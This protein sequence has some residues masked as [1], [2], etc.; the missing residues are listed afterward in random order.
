M[1]GPSKLITYDD[2][3]TTP[4]NKLE[5]IVSGESRIMPPSSSTGGNGRCSWGDLD[6]ASSGFCSLIAFPT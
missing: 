2:L 5:E 4:E 3:L 6:S 1:S